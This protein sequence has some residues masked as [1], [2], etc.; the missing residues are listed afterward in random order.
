[1]YD[2]SFSVSSVHE[3]PVLEPLIFSTVNVNP[4]LLGWRNGSY[5]LDGS[6]LAEE[7]SGA[8]QGAKWEGDSG[9]HTSS[10]LLERA[11]ASH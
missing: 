3:V 5:G 4:L 6:C 11:D 8:S 10:C 7:N 1:M 9:S 2:T